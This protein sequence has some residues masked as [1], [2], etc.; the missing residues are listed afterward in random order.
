MNYITIDAA[1]AMAYIDDLLIFSDTFEDHLK[2]IENGLKIKPTKCEWAKD[3]VT[4][5]G[6]IISAQGITTEPKNTE[7]IAKFPVPKSVKD[8]QKKKMYKKKCTKEK[9]E[10]TK[11]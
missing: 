10:R 6:H 2:H 7:K 3:S 11:K 4:F 9:V 5:L 8:V 1:H